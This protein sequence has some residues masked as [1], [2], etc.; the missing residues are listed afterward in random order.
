MNKYQALER[1]AIDNDERKARKAKAEIERLRKTVTRLSDE[2]YEYAEQIE[3]LTRELAKVKKLLTE[4]DG[5][6][7]DIGCKSSYLE[8]ESRCNCCHVSVREYLSARKGE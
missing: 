7:H 3:V 5:G 1:A 4:R 2:A 6:A 8:D